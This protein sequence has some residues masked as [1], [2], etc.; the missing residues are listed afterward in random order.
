M[1]K[2]GD[3]IDIT[4]NKYLFNSPARKVLMNSII[5]SDYLTIGEGVCNINKKI[6]I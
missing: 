6:I 2:E 3:I 5:T 4:M 1:P